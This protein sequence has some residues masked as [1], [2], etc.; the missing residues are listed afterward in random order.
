MRTRG[1]AGEG[2]LPVGWPAGHASSSS[3]TTQTINWRR[4]VFGPDPS[5][6]LRRVLLW[7]AATLILFHYLLVPIKVIGASMTPT[8]RDGAVNL[9]N[10]LAYSRK[11]PRRGDVVVLHDGEDMILKRIIALPGET[12]ALEDG[13][14][15]INGV[16][17]HDQFS[18]DPVISDFDPVTLGADEYFVIG[19]NRTASIFGKFSKNAILGK[20]V[21]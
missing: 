12:V 16:P 7:S 4:L 21:F 8:Y 10:R 2:W 1:W 18:V 6:T 17:L 20:I 13:Q 19:D 9:I 11:A 3:Q 5:R 15:Q 14:F